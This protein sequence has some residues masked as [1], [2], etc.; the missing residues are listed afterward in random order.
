MLR[1]A[2]ANCPDV[3]WDDPADK[4]AFWHVAYHALFYT[5][6]YLSESEATF[7][8]WPRCRET[9]NLLAPAPWPPY[10]G[11][12]ITKPYTPADILEYIA[13]CDAQVDA[14]TPRL[15]PCAASG[16][17]HPCLVD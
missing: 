14:L 16:E 9:Y 12:Q 10:P 13:F 11:P 17:G 2:V 7:A 15:D 6:L 3:L 5:N 4:A 8:A 1:Q